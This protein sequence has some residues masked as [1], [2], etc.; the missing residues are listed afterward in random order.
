MLL[1]ISIKFNKICPMRLSINR[2]TKRSFCAIA[3]I[4]LCG[5]SAIAQGIT[6]ANEFFK[7]VSDKYATFKDYQAEVDIKIDKTDMA[8]TVTYL[9]PDK[10]RMDFSN[11]AE[12][13][14]V[15]DGKRLVCYLPDSGAVLTQDATGENPTTSEGLSLLRRYYTVSY[16]IGQGEVPLDEG[17]DEMVVKLILWR[18]TGSESFRS[19]RI[20]IVPETK[21]IRRI[22]AT[23][24]DGI[25][26][27]FDFKTYEIN[28]GLTAKR[29]EYNIPSAAN[30]YD[31][32]L[33][34][35]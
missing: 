23:T 30:N 28:Q 26:Y 3:I 15:Y 19:I 33:F 1:T 34:S 8:A 5:F 27:Q 14:I 31:N 18:R 12:Q 11:P 13:T 25:V 2:I 32:F 17:S 21:L 35:D 9:A 29:F 20:S 6:T 10:M 24:P 4:V 7:S 16:E 22:I